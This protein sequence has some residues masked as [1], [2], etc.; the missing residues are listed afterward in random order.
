MPRIIFACCILF[1]I[2]SCNWSGK[3]VEQE[4]VDSCIAIKADKRKAL[5][6]AD[7]IFW[8]KR[9]QDDTNSFTANVVLAN[10]LQQKFLLDGKVQQ[11][12]Q[13]NTQL[14][15]I[16]QLS[17]QKEAG[18]LRSLAALKLLQHQFSAAEAYAAD[19]YTLGSERF[20]TNLLLF[21]ISLELGK[22]SKAADYLA[23][24]KSNNEY[25]YF[26]R[27]SKY[28]HWL[29]NVDSAVSAMQKA[30]T[31]A[32][33]NVH[34]AQAALSNAGDLYLHE[35][36]VKKAYAMYKKS[37]QLEANDNH[38]LMGIA[39]IAMLKEGNIVLAEKC[40]DTVAART[41]LPDALWYKV[42]IAEAK[43]D[44]SLQYKT[45]LAFKNRVTDTAYGN[46]YNK[47]LIQLYV[48]VLQNYSLALE[49]AEKELLNRSTAQT[50]SWYVYALHKNGQNE[51]ALRVYDAH[52]AGKPLEA[53]ELYWMGKFL[54]KM[55]KWYNADKFLEAAEQNKYDLSPAQAADL[56]RLLAGK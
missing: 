9:L 40:I 21:D 7:S 3:V 48:G 11:L 54:Q 36:E 32:N 56:K 12:A 49:I 29:G 20:E 31:L 16:N 53:L 41:L 46:M 19:A 39:K 44:S 15:K 30:A 35:G 51:K 52:I 2:T 37:L 27:L 18:V 55:E 13:A 42:W 23:T 26:F 6:I 14:T 38:S 22:Y 17:A 28:Q 45:A 50:Y 24:C 34:L 5:L 47:Y 4:F 25:S 8:Q 33:K 43:K 10:L 1:I